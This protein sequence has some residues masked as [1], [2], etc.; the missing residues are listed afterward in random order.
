MVIMSAAEP[1]SSG[2]L[3]R[4]KRL[5]WHLFVAPALAI[6]IGYVSTLGVSAFEGG[7]GYAALGVTLFVLVA[8]VPVLLMA[9]KSF[10]RM[11]RPWRLGLLALAVVP[12]ALAIYPLL[13]TFGSGYL[14][15]YRSDKAEA[16]RV[17][18]IKAA[19]DAD[20]KAGLWRGGLPRCMSLSENAW[21]NKCASPVDLRHCWNITPDEANKYEG[22]NHECSNNDWQWVRVEPG[23]KGAARP[24][25]RSYSGSCVAPARIECSVAV[26]AEQPMSAKCP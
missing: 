15:Q 20:W 25:C 8:Y 6:A 17:A 3:A 18:D 19:N 7:R 16:R 13:N 10:R 4:L 24:W 23:Q 11:A 22:V 1:P 2:F 9:L 21:Y 14:T 26:T 12:W 5:A